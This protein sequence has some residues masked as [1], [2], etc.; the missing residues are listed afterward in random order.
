MPVAI[1][2]PV[3]WNSD[4]RPSGCGGDREPVAEDELPHLSE[5]DRKARQLIDAY[6]EL[7]A[8][9]RVDQAE[10]VADF[11]RETAY[12]WANR[13]LA[14]RCMEARD[15]IDEV[16]L[17]KLTYGGR[18]LDHHRLLEQFSE[19]RPHCLPGTPIRLGVIRHALGLVANRGLIL[20]VVA[21]IENRQPRMP[22]RAACRSA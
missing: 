9:A 10:A 19:E 5:A 7:R 21:D 11:V 2:T 15:L 20:V 13:L 4:W 1:G 3:I 6:L 8:D 18:S 17:Q 12:T 16:I 22:S 14:L